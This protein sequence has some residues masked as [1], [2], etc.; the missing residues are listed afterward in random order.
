MN[1]FQEK[2]R[3]RKILFS[4]PTI[5]LFSVV[6]I[7]FLAETI[8][9]YIKKNEAVTLDERMEAE[10]LDLRQR[11]DEL[12]KKIYDL[13]TEAGIEKEVRNK[14]NVQKEGE[15]VLVIVDKPD[16]NDKNNLDGEGNGFFSKI[17]NWIKNIF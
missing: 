11:K 16:E 2:R 12:E 8:G 4:W 17:W 13:Q 5:I 1:E 3:I 9:I 6:A 15:K 7:F 10:L 14:F